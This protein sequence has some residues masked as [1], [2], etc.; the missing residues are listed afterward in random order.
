MFDAFTGEPP[1]LR[2]ARW[3]GLSFLVHALVIVAAWRIMLSRGP[4]LDAPRVVV[5]YSPARP[6]PPPPAGAR[7]AEVHKARKPEIIPHKVS[8]I[9]QPRETIKPAD[10][11]EKSEPAGVVGGVAG[12][13]AGGV[14]GGQGTGPAE[15]GSGMSPPRLLSGPTIQYT[16]KAL[17]NDV[18]G[19]MIVRCVLTVQGEVQQCQVQQHVRFMDN[20]VVETLQKRRYTPVLSQ[21]RPI[22]VYYTFRIRLTLP[23]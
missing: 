9:V 1:H 4:I 19:L 23:R 5:T 10:Q 8:A 15:F 3:M 17:E 20:A 16:D 21:G 7:K 13:V 2:R 18:E 14:V 6:P 11:E 22:D 12:G